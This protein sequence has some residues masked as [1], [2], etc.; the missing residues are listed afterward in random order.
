MSEENKIKINTHSPQEYIERNR[1]N[2]ET[3][4]NY[5]SGDSIDD[6]VPETVPDRVEGHTL[7]DKQYSEEMY[8]EEQLAKHAGSNENI[9]TVD[10]IPSR[11]EHN[12]TR[13]NWHFDPFRD[14]YSE[15]TFIVP[16]RFTND[17]SDVCAAAIENNI[18]M[19]IGNYR[20]RNDSRQDHDL[21]DAEM[22]DIKRAT[23]GKIK[24]IVAMHKVPIFNHNDRSGEKN[25]DPVYEVLHRIIEWSEMDIH[26]SR[27]HIQYL[28][29]VTQ[30]HI[31][32]QMRYARPKFR[33]MWTDA[34]ADK[35]PL[36]LRRI[37]IH[38]QDWELG[39]VWQFGNTYHQG[40][41]SGSAVTYDW[42]NMPHGTANF[43][44]TPRVTFQMTGFVGE[45]MQNLID[46]S[47]QGAPT[48]EVEV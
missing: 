20:Q 12:K 22:M 48:L 9:F 37:L 33:K 39:H 29:Q 21:H 46:R 5:Y 41:K 24:D 7:E 4:K 15:Q 38:L 25:P 28:G 43:G 6:L 36:K 42:C 30:F 3:G 17:F 2:F 14:P 45:K 8:S 1:A 16:V 11:W 13:S 23:A 10:G 26:Q 34:G 31:D 47:L 18:P 40:Y 27:L 32:Q 35:N 19:S 44:F